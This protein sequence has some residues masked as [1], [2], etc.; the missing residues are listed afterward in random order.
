MDVYQPIYD[1]VRSRLSNGDIGAAIETVMRDANI[2]HHAEMAAE[3]RQAASE[4]E[5]PSVLYRPTLTLDGTAWCSGE[6]LQ[7]GVAGFGDS[8]DLA[9]RDFDRAWYATTKVQVDLTTESKGET[10]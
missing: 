10:V 5:R 8:P 2:G 1:A 6:N 4:Y 7:E 9:M 3:I